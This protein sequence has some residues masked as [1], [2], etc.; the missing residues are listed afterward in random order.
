MRVAITEDSRR[1]VKVLRDEVELICDGMKQ[2]CGESEM[3]V[4]GE[5]GRDMSE[6]R[7]I[8]YLLP[9]GCSCG[10]GAFPFSW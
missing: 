6:R 5:E 3:K 8:L 7:T 10:A 2:S 1:G 9:T 4:V